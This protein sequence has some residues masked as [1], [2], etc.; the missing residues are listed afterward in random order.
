[1]RLALSNCWDC[2]FQVSGCCTWF[3]D[4]RRIPLDI[5]D[6]GCKYYRQR[7][8]KDI[9]TDNIITHLINTFDGEIIN[10]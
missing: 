5:V 1:M 9:K 8:E 4:E 2:G 10:S 3:P 7:T 6:K